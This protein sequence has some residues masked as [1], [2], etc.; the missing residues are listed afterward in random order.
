MPI[1]TFFI[2]KLC[3]RCGRKLGEKRAMSFFTSETLCENCSANEEE[4]RKKIR[5]QHGDSTAD[6]RYQGIGL[7]VRHKKKPK[8]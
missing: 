7:K 6:L 2:Q 3:D 8:K 5:E 1:H 4:I